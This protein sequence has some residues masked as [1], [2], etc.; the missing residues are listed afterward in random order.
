MWQDG[1]LIALAP[2]YVETSAGGRRILPIGISVSDYLDLLVAADAPDALD[3][4][5]NQIAKMEQAW[6]E[7]ELTELA[8][9]AAGLRFSCPDD[10]AEETGITVPYPMLALPS[11]LAGLRQVI[12]VRRRRSLTG[13][14][15]R[16]ARHGTVEII[17]GG[18][19]LQA[20][21]AN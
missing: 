18:Q 9:D 3:I 2:C 7:W 15:N 16:A 6:D 17:D 8:P 14:R 4:T 21:C 5:V 12:P 10:W 20:S 19:I 1:R 11:D 13:A